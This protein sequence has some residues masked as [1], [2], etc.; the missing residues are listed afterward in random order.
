MASVTLSRAVLSL[1]DDPSQM[2]VFYTSGRSRQ[3]QVPGSV[4]RM[5]NGR[6]RT[7]RRAGTATR[8]GVTA[9][10]V[11]PDVQEMIEEWAGHTVLYRDSWGQKMYCAYFDPAVTDYNDR[12]RRDV[13]LMLVEVTVSEYA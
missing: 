6:M 12:S 9:T 10:Y 13:A 8:I 4:M 2:V 7:V 5:A 11:T 3:V 1:A